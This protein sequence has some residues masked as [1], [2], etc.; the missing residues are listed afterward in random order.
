MLR[1]TS[2]MPTSS[3]LLLL[4]SSGS[5][6]NV[7]QLL[8]PPPLVLGLT[9]NWPQSRAAAESLV[10][11]PVKMPASSRNMPTWMVRHTAEDGRA[12]DGHT[13]TVTH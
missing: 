7:L 6:A 11:R 4:L 3:S 2:G 12:G 8:L 9:L 13:T 1:L 5:G 10:M